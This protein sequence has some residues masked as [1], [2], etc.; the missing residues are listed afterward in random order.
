MATTITV[1]NAQRGDRLT[2]IETRTKRDRQRLA[3]I[4]EE[5]KGEGGAMFAEVEGEQHRLVGYDPNKD[6]LI[7]QGRIRK[8]R[9][10]AKGAKV[11][12][13]APSAGG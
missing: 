6:Q 12:V 13:V 1:F 2:E 11:Y 10:P 9:L 4:I 7:V 5:K 8:R 3:R